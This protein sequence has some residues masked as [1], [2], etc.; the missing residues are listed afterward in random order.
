MRH[1]IPKRLPLIAVFAFLLSNQLQAQPSQ[2]SPRL[3]AE[4]STLLN[5]YSIKKPGLTS[6]KL[7][8]GLGPGQGQ[9]FLGAIDADLAGTAYWIY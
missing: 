2:N 6:S 1:A 4:L 5:V 9:P 8:I 3:D 7:A